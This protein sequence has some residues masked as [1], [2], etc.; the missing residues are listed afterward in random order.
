[1]II[2]LACADR[3]TWL[4]CCR[5]ICW[6]RRWWLFCHWWRFV[7]LKGNSAMLHSFTFIWRIQVKIYVGFIYS[8]SMV[9]LKRAMYVN[10]II[11]I[12]KYNFKFVNVFDFDCGYFICLCCKLFSICYCDFTRWYIFVNFSFNR[13]AN[14]IMWTF[15]MMNFS[16]VPKDFQPGSKYVFRSL[17]FYP[18]KR[19]MIGTHTSI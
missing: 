5:R 11:K 3:F 8:F 14:A 16:I 17:S 19:I 7:T 10:S 2:C 6:L 1:M 4:L 9:N 12:Q 15:E 18:C 13:P